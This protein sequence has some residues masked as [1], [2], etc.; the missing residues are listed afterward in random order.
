MKLNE[1]RQSISEEKLRGAHLAWTP[2]DGQ[3]FIASH[4]ELFLKAGYK[5]SIVGSVAKKGF[6]DHDLDI[7]LTPTPQALKDDDFDIE[8]IV[9]YSGWKLTKSNYN[10]EMFTVQLTDGRYV[11]FWL[12][13]E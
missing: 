3:K 13:E 5:A 1:L 11:D 2:D 10:Y 9:D 4:Q 8:M 6:S 7:L 12:S